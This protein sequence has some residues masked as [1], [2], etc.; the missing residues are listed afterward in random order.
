MKIGFWYMVNRA[1]IREA[2]FDCFLLACT[3][4]VVGIGTLFVLFIFIRFGFY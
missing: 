1:R 2:V 3:Y 4:L